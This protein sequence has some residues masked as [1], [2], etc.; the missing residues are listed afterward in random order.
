M[1]FF[2]HQDEARSQT[3]KLVFLFVAAVVTLIVLT[4]F[5]VFALFF[6][7]E[8][9]DVGLSVDMLGSE[10][11]LG[12]TAVVLAVVGLGT[13]FRLVQLGGGG[14]AVA[15]AMGGRLLN[16]S[17]RDAD[18]RKILNVVE[19]M[20]IA[21]G[22][23]VPPVYL[24]EEKS[25]NAFAAGY[26]AR[27]AVIGITRGCIQ[28]LDRD[29]LQGV[30]AHEFSHIFNG[31]MRLNIRLMGLLYG[32]MVL[33]IIGYH[34]LRSSRYRS[35][36]RSSKGNGGGIIFLGLGLMVIG[37]GGTF[38]GNMIK[39]AVSRQ[40]EY[41][42]DASAVQYTRNPEGIG[43][44]LKKIGGFPSGSVIDG[45]DVSEISHMLFCDGIK[46][47]FSSLFATHPPINKRIQRIDPQWH[48]GSARQ[49][50]SASE[51]AGEEGASHF[52]G[53]SGGSALDNIGS[54]TV[55]NISQAATTLASIPAIVIEE[56]HNTMSAS[57]MIYSLLIN[58]SDEATASCQMQILK[59]EL[60]DNDFQALEI[61]RKEVASVKR[62]DY[63]V[64][65]DLAMPS[66]KQLS[67]IQY[68]F[69]MAVLGK[70]IM[71]D[72]E[73][74]LFEWCL[75]KILRYTLDER[76]DRRLKS[77][78]LKSLH[79][80]C[81]VL[82][83]VLA[84]SGQQDEKEAESAFLAAKEYLELNMGMQ[85]RHNIGANT[86]QL[87]KAL[88]SLNNLKPL[89]KPKLLKAMAAAINAD[90]HVTAEEGE[91]LRAVGSLLDCPIPPLLPEQRFI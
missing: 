39:S 86:G 52:A 37:Y 73:I 67:K 88:D 8:T 71:A 78:S 2:A 85:Y 44:A 77:R 33:G 66:L 13:M 47:S 69:F 28:E 89:E 58:L 36:S 3:R 18:E 46:H 19:E 74:S 51:I 32:I 65:V 61:I 90:G 42:A 63:L 7:A 15:E 27:D 68:R 26:K 83:S 59:Q 57:L 87:E 49:S 62:E 64:L 48:G 38:F 84:F 11:F 60:A 70:L 35:S 41:L 81:E 34:I 25:I 29:E 1:N 75:F 54:P 76:T 30:I 20:A 9:Q 72:N 4:S 16:T 23:P 40:R 5:L 56:A 45:K 6:A 31:D 17:T 80:D 53:N 12:V 21:S 82:L 22:S 10:V 50:A 91:L 14:K 79:K 43:G 24:M 55:E